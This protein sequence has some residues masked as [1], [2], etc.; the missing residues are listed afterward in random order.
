MPQLC[1]PVHVVNVRLKRF[2][3][4]F[5]GTQMRNLTNV[6]AVGPTARLSRGHCTIVL[7]DGSRLQSFELGHFLCALKRCH[8]KVAR[9]EHVACIQPLK[10]GNVSLRGFWLFVSFPGIRKMQDLEWLASKV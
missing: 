10:A 8:G 7:A 1:P 9:L 4:L 3:L 5:L 2:V 6:P